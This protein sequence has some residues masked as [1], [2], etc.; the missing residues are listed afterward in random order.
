MITNQTNW[1]GASFR[2]NITIMIQQVYIFSNQR[3]KKE[4]DNAKKGKFDWKIVNNIEDACLKRRN[5]DSATT[6]DWWKIP[7]Q[8]LV[9]FGASFVLIDPTYSL[10]I[11]NWIKWTRG[12]RRGKIWLAKLRNLQNIVVGA[13][14]NILLS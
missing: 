13:F 8:V 2:K 7:D 6:K 5:L 1:S 4:E 12:Y 10:S 11:R 14:Q 9:L 3:T